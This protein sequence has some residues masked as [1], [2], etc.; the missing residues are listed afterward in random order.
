MTGNV[1]EWTDD[2]YAPSHAGRSPPTTS[3]LGRAARPTTLGSR[4]RTT[5]TPPASPGAHL[6]RRVIKGGSHLCAPNYC[7][8]YRPAARQAETMETSTSHI[9]FRGIGPA[10]A[11]GH[12]LAARRLVRSSRRAAS[13]RRQLMHRGTKRW[14]LWVGKLFVL[15]IY[16]V[17][18]AYS[19]IV[20]MAFVLQLLGANPT[21]DF[22]DWVY[23]AAAS[24]TEPFRGIFPTTQVTSARLQRVAALRA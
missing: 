7:L 1:W 9:G 24:I 15:V 17:L 3:H 2:Y 10:A 16:L 18:L 6:P 21:S 4:R 11:E 23:R 14:I 20:G 13:T 22:A 12:P 5:A 8:R 19:V